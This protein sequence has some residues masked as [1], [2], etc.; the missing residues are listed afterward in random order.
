MITGWF[1][2]FRKSSAIAL[3]WLVLT[4][5]ALAEEP[6]VLVVGDSLSAAYGIDLDDGWVR[7]L[8]QRLATENY[9]HRVVNGSISG[10]TSGGGLARLPA[11][12]DEYE[13]AVVILELGGNDGLRGFPIPAMRRNLAAMIEMSRDI[14]AE[15]LLVGMQIP[16][17][18][19]QR[20][21]QIFATTFPELA[22][23]Y[24]VALVPFMLLHLA[25]DPELMQADGIH[26]VASAQ[27]QIL[28]N[29]WPYLQPLL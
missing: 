8:E 2:R 6:V 16:P 25:T 22:T 12:L 5:A 21:S 26:P 24:D 13:P 20:Y 29:I 9:P 19:G 11:L 1:K 15:V 23:E 3:L 18:Y 7:L 28:D 10:D 14:G 4:P 27:P 17:N